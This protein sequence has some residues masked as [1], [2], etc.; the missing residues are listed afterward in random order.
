M[1]PVVA[2]GCGFPAWKLGV[3]GI[4]ERLGKWLLGTLAAAMGESG[5][6]QPVPRGWVFM[7]FFKKPEGLPEL[8]VECNFLTGGEP[9][10]P[11]KAG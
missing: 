6:A 1:P 4:N 11:A 8:L 3:E 5:A 9:G 2:K 10:S 7:D